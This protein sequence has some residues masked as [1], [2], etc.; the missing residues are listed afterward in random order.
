[1]QCLR[2]TGATKHE[3]KQPF[4]NM[5]MQSHKDMHLLKYHKG[6]EYIYI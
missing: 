1:M 6:G 3:K 5:R 2:L 4:M